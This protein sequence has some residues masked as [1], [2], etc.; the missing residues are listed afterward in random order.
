MDLKVV[1]SRFK[2]DYLILMK[3]L[4]ER[5]KPPKLHEFSN[6]LI[7]PYNVTL[8]AIYIPYDKTI[9]I[10][11][12]LPREIEKLINNPSAQ[13]FLLD[14]VLLEE[15]CHYLHHHYLQENYLSMFNATRNY[16]PNLRLVKNENDVEELMKKDEIVKYRVWMEGLAKSIALQTC[17]K[18]YRLN[19]EYVMQLIRRNRIDD[20]L[21]VIDLYAIDRFIFKNLTELKTALQSRCILI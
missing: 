13:E 17:C 4:E 20:P 10:Y 8:G 7:F 9:Y 12:D 21:S 16:K 14:F 5:I 3:L 1:R 19:L 2:K 15:A 11:K 6:K 18:K